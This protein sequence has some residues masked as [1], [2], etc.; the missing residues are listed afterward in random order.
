MCIAGFSQTSDLLYLNA[1]AQWGPWFQI[2]LA[3]LNVWEMFLER[4]QSS[5]C[6][7]RACPAIVAQNK[8][9]RQH[10]QAGWFQRGGGLI[11]V[12]PHASS[13]QSRT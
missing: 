10:E 3:P 9:H 1:K 4:R 2:N 12:H 13:S 8:D 5:S 11:R 6:G 7:L